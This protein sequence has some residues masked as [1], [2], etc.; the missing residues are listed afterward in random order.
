MGEFTSHSW[1]YGVVVIWYNLSRPFLGY[2]LSIF[3]CG[4]QLHG[5]IHSCHSS[6]D[7]NEKPSLGPMWTAC[8]DDIWQCGNIWETLVGLYTSVISLSENVT[9][10][11][12][13][14]F[15]LP[16]FA[17]TSTHL[18]GMMHSLRTAPHRAVWGLTSF[19]FYLGMREQD[20]WAILLLRKCLLYL[21]HCF[22]LF[23]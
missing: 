21:N 8:S 2:L 5:C 12:C 22:L 4:T 16:S 13:Y 9:N 11:P 7:G 20:H 23:V 1:V 14:H 10:L 18:L 3:T 15:Y 17:V 19:H 6:Q